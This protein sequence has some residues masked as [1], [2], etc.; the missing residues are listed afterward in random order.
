MADSFKSRSL[1]RSYR[2]SMIRCTS[3]VVGAAEHFVWLT[4]RV[5]EQHR[6]RF[7]FADGNAAGVLAA[8]EAYRCPDGGFGYGL[9]PDMRGPVSQ[10]LH[11]HAALS[12]LDEVG[13]CHGERVVSL[14]EYL[15][16]ITAPDGGVPGV[17]PTQR[18]YPRAPFMP[19]IDDPPGALLTTG[20][21][22]GVLHKNNVEHAWLERATAFCWDRISGLGDTHPYEVHAAVAFLD[23]VPEQERARSVARELGQRVREQRLVLLDPAR[24]EEV[25]VA[26]GYGPGEWHYAYDYAPTPTSLARS[27]FRDDE[28]DVALDTLAG[29]QEPDGGWPVRWRAWAPGS[30]LEARPRVTIEALRTLRAYD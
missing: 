25:P 10:P 3:D 11:V 1:S 14:C 5:L 6:F 22:A 21:L 29:A 8:L 13:Q 7:L 15:T 20:L 12:V 18:D 2:G 19:V 24:A 16:S 30:L 23:H 26:P 9:E 28:M 4:G 17:L 27:W